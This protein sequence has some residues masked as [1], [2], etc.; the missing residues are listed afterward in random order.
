MATPPPPHGTGPYAGPQPPGPYISPQAP[1]IS[2][3]YAPQQAPGVGEPYA[4]QAPYAAPQAGTPYPQQSGPYTA[5]PQA[6]PYPPQPHGLYAP[7]PGSPACGICGA[8]PA[9]PATVRGHQGF[10][11]L[12]RF[13][14]RRGAFCRDCGLA[15]V[16][17]MSAKTL[18]QGWWGPLSV[19]ITP[20]TLLMNI[21]PA[22]RFRKLAAPT[23]GF[24][25]PLDPGKTLLR[26]PEALLFLVPMVFV[27][28]AIPVLMVIGLLA[29][30]DQGRAGPG[31][32]KAPTLAIGACVRNDGDWED[33][34]LQVTDCGA[35]DAQ[36]KVTRR[37]EKAGSTCA[38]GELYAHLKY[39]PG[40][41][42]VSCLKPLR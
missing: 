20:L 2:G 26:R 3:P 24:R 15:S 28:V 14:S 21:G 37:L 35:T 36:Y 30:G 32:E 13:L 17:D 25:P 8:L 16:R 22:G 1:Q 11:V 31:V 9:V 4:P 38:D 27:A 19:A 33:Q 6:G 18:W 40:G 29:G 10:L 7:S 41:T 12:M 34:D 39:G 5:P 42:T 23:G